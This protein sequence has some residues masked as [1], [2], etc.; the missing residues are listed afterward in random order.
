[1][2]TLIKPIDD[3]DVLHGFLSAD[4]A[5]C[6]Y[7]LGDLDDAYFPWC[8]W[9]GAYDGDELKLV[10][11]LYKGLSVPVTLTYG[12][13]AYVEELFEAVYHQ[14]PDRFYC[15]VL[16]G[17]L[18][19]LARHYETEELH[20]MLRMALGRDEYAPRQVDLDVVRLGH[21]HT[22]QIV[23]LYE[24]YPDNFFEPYQLETGLY[25]GILDRSG[26]DLVSIAGIHV[27]SNAYDIG[28]IGNLVT[29][30]EHRGKNLATRVTGRLLNEVFERVSLAALNV[31][32][33]N[34]AALRTYQTFGFRP[35]HRYYEGLVKRRMLPPG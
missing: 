4:R 34:T 28:V 21:R 12:D 9:W 6:A 7:Q 24:H 32:E 27:L 11:L 13:S 15:H 5:A 17:H 20:L 18:P 14:L 26:G 29:H 8:D 35:H 2:T 19:G 30:P 1:M 10:L 3:R 25:F 16:E 31:D 22:A 23:S 33:A